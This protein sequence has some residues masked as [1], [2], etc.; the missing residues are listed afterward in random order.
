M[1]YKT[2]KVF[3]KDIKHFMSNY[4]Q[5]SAPVISP[6]ATGAAAAE[7]ESK[8][9]SR[10]RGMMVGRGMLPMRRREESPAAAEQRPPPPAPSQPPV[11]LATE[12][13]KL[14]KL[15]LVEESQTPTSKP[16]PALAAVAKRSDDGQTVLTSTA[17]GGAGGGAATDSSRSKAEQ[18]LRVVE[19]IQRKSPVRKTGEI[20]EHMNFVANYIK[21]KCRNSG[22]YQYVVHFNPPVDSK[23]HRI[24]MVYILSEIIGDVRLFDGVTLFLPICLKDRVCSKSSFTISTLFAYVLVSQYTDHCGACQAQA[25]RSRSRRRDK[26]SADKDIAA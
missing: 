14:S 7:R 1:I 8:T 10:G 6:R 18:E 11:S 5:V 22:V 26:N 15:T 9:M 4:L 23:Y 20:G 16:I 24:K 19:H 3:K 12:T 13:S 21:L 25:Q 17:S 2:I